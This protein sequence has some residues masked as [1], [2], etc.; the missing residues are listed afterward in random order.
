MTDAFQTSCTTIILAAGEGKRMRSDTPKVLHPIAG[1]PMVNHVIDT[2]LE[3]GSDTVAVVVGNQAERVEAAVRDHSAAVSTHIQHERKGT[4]HAVLAAREAIERAQGDL[5][6]LYGDVPLIRAE[7]IDSARDALRSGSDVVV[8]GFHTAQPTGYGRLLTQGSQLLAIRE[9]KDATDEER[10]VTFCNSGIMAFRAEHALDLLDAVGSA[11]AQGEYYL[12]DTVEIARERGLNAVAIEVPEA[13]T[14]GVNDRVQLAQVEELWQQRRREV[15]MRDGVT[16][17]APDTVILHYDTEL[18][19]DCVIEPNV[20]FAQGVTVAS[21]ATIRA[22]SHLEG[23]AVGE[24]AVVGPYARLRPGAA[25]GTSAKVGNFVEIKGAT[26]G[27]GAKVNHLSYIGDAEVGAKANVG[28]GTITCNYDGYNKWKTQIG[29]GAFI[30][31]NT[32][33]VAPVTVGDGIITA[34]GSVITNDV[35]ADALAITRADQK[36]IPGKA[37]ELHVRNAA[38]KAKRTAN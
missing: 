14:L 18:A 30:G 23:A 37:R 16:M 13:D 17:T 32:S 20:V 25:V 26:L 12:T 29:E 5:V 4:A 9:E 1:L 11:N 35:E 33:L 3:A 38:T 24:G 6:I 8:L 21:G 27:E 31:S 2:A 22:F 10:K 36:N 7:T 28:A 15:A 34:A 19:S